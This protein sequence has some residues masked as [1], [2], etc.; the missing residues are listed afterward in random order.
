MAIDVSSLSGT[1]TN[2][3]LQ[4]GLQI[5]KLFVIY[6]V[7]LLAYSVLIFKFYRFV[8]KRDIFD[9]DLQQ[10]STSDVTWI[11]KLGGVF[12]YIIE[13]LVIFPLFTL[14]WSAVLFVLLAFLAKNQ[15]TETMLLAAMAIVAI[16]RATAYYNED[17]SKDL[18]KILPFTLLGI[19]IIDTS[20]FSLSTSIELIKSIPS[21]L[22]NIVYYFLAI[23]L[24][25]FILRFGHG[26]ISLFKSDEEDRKKKKDED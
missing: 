9:L 16:V 24:L 22:S 11:K 2:L 4:E 26:I 17:L 3:N 20:Y 5:L 18:A 8:A 13:Y 7:G 6:V 21:F 14:L 12:F 1:I 15:A 25:E 19:F 10:Y 23:V